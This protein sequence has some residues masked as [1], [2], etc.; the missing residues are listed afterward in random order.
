M[1]Y[2]YGTDNND[3]LYGIDD[4]E[5][6]IYSYLGDDHIW[7]GSLSD[8][9]YLDG[10]AGSTNGL[11]NQEV[12]AGAGDDYIY[13][14]SGKDYI[15]GED[16]DDTIYGGGSAQDYLSGGAGDDYIDGDGKLYGGDG[17][18]TIYADHFKSVYG[19]AGNDYILI[20]YKGYDSSSSVQGGA[21]NDMIV[22]GQYADKLYGA[23]NNDSSEN[24]YDGANDSIYGNGGDDL[25]VGEA[26]NDTLHGGDGDDVI[27]GGLDHDK[28]YGN[29]GNDE[30]IADDYSTNIP[31]GSTQSGNDLLDGGAGNDIMY[32][33]GGNDT[34]YF[35]SGNDSIGYNSTY[36]G[37]DGGSDKIKFTEDMADI[38]AYITLS[39]S[40][41]D[42]IVTYNN[43]G[44]L[45]V[46]E[47]YSGNA[48]DQIEY[49]SFSDGS[50]S[51]IR[52]EN[53]VM[54]TNSAETIYGDTNSSQYN[55]LI[56]AF[57][58]NDIIDALTGND[59]VYAGD[60]DDVVYGGSGRDWL[61][62]NDGDD[63]LNGG[64][65]NDFI[66]GQNGD[67]II[68]GD[69][70]NDSLAGYN[71]ND[72]IY[73]DIGNDFLYG[74]SGNDTLYGNDDDDTLYGN[75]GTDFLNGGAGEDTMTGGTG[76][77]TFIFEASSALSDSDTIKDF[78]IS[79][80][81]VI[82]IS[83]VLQNYDP[84]NDALSDFVS[85]TDDGTDSQL[86]IDYDGTASSYTFTEIATLEN[87][88]GL[89]LSN[90]VSNG[91]LII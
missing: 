51:L 1:N 48:S 33:Y 30:L 76:A 41:N 7:G 46:F 31:T 89:D 72:T 34:Y 25:I 65:D 43:V 20:T 68:H 49:L 37:E 86:M 71:D 32:G 2:I 13:G 16:G 90:M 15:K 85:I 80:S 39:Q 21:G 45:T 24:I 87:I 53:L 77:D 78:N 17:N 19:G 64:D 79:E 44:T 57:Q 81:D 62:G 35:S 28:L 58:G 23:L 47:H 63:T 26:G 83:D 84:L 50:I 67:D 18:D 10:G 75:D 3:S 12:Y 56:Y 11:P 5:N 61:Y 59:Y 40:G 54:Y 69:A 73:G 52:S 22:G 91:D 74:G 29:D 42:L 27:R 88:I 8:W 14:G 38:G 55:D 6:T 60:G 82:D 66:Y 36:T 4:E 9:I 70:G